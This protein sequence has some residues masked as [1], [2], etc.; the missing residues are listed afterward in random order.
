MTA[1]TPRGTAPTQ[2][3]GSGPAVD[4]QANVITDGHTVFLVFHEQATAL[5]TPEIIDAGYLQDKGHVD[6]APTGT[7]VV[8]GGILSPLL[9]RSKPG[10][11]RSRPA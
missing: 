11:E 10:E 8:F 1:N 3:D 6:T 9:L 4:A 7:H 5:V 2:Y